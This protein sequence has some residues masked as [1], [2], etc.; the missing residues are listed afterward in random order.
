MQVELSATPPRTT[1]IYAHISARFTRQSFVGLL[2][3]PCQYS[4]SCPMWDNFYPAARRR[5]SRRLRGSS[6]WACTGRANDCNDCNDCNGCM[7]FERVGGTRRTAHRF[8]LEVFAP[9]GFG[10]EPCPP[11]PEHVGVSLLRRLLRPTGGHPW[12]PAEQF[13]RLPRREIGQHGITIT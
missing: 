11:E 2:G 3:Y 8:R 6:L 12:R 5:D 9:P 4:I 10:R 1:G 13:S 7:L